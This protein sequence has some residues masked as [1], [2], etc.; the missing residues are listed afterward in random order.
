MNDDVDGPLKDD[1]PTRAFIALVEEDGA[2]ARPRLED[3]D[4]CQLSLDHRR[5]MRKRFQVQ[6][7]FVDDVDLAKAMDEE[8]GEGV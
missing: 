2:G 8:K 5:Q 6:K 1:V 3:K 4:R 7:F